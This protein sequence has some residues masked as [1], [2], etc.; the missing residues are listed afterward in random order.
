MVSVAQ[1]VERLVDEEPV[2]EVRSLSGADS[3]WSLRF[4]NHPRLASFLTAR[5]LSRHP[6]RW[7][8]RPELAI[9]ARRRRDEAIAQPISCIA[10]PRAHPARSDVPHC[11]RF[12]ANRLARPGSS[13][14]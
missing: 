11:F 10:F 5:Q 6:L 9:W 7:T 8:R 14:H 13:W 2:Y 12:H 3:V 4:T 1:N